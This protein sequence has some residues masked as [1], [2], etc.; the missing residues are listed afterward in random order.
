MPL[1]VVPIFRQIP[2]MCACNETVPSLESRVGY[3]VH[4]CALFSGYF[5]SMG[6]LRVIRQC[7]E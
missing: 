3:K 2:N 1:S 7:F 4:L 5:P 6:E